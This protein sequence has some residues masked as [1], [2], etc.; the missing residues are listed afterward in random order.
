MVGGTYH[1]GTMI[2]NGDLYRW[3]KATPQAG[4]WP[5]WQ[6]TT[7]AICE[8]G[9]CHAG[10]HDGGA[11]RYST[12]RFD[13]IDVPFDGSKNPNTGYWFG[14]YGILNGPGLPQL[15]HRG[16]EL[17]RSE[18][19][20]LSNVGAHFERRSRG[21]MLVSGGVHVDRG[22]TWGAN[23]AQGP[24]QSTSTS[25]VRSP[26]RLVQDGK[27]GTKSFARSRRGRLVKTG[28]TAPLRRIT[29]VPTNVV[30]GGV[31]I[32]TTNAVHSAYCR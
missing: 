17:L 26:N 12:D 14:E 22:A 3:G 27:P 18:D 2:R 23:T 10:Y 8:P 15:H 32:G 4:G 30:N 11:F 19:G 7:S 13:R 6:E 20:G 31:Y 16:S 5:S 21:F 25:T 9:R 28:P 1:N 29:L 24:N